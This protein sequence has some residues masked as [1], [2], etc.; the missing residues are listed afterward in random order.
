MRRSVLFWILT[1]PAILIGS[2]FITLQGIDYFGASCPS[3]TTLSL[4]PPFARYS[5]SGAAWIANFPEWSD[6]ADTDETPNRSTAMVCENG[7]PLG[8]AHSVHADV[9]T[10][11]RG[12]FS[13]WGTIVVFSA[14]DNSDPNANGRRYRIVR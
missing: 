12:R 8:P 6:T 5:A 10:N 14:S 11:G 3:G 7:H 4:A 9:A 13:H 1:G 2:F